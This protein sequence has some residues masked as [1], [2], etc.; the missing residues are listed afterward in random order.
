[1]KF[2]KIFAVATGIVLV[3][4]SVVLAAD[5]LSLQEFVRMAANKRHRMDIRK[6]SEVHMQPGSSHL[7]VKV[8]GD[9]VK[10]VEYGSNTIEVRRIKLQPGEVVET[11]ARGGRWEFRSPEKLAE[12]LGETAATPESSPAETPKVEAAAPAPEKAVAPAAKSSSSGLLEGKKG[13]LIVRNFEELQKVSSRR[14][15]EM[16]KDG[17]RLAQLSRAIEVTDD[18]LVFMGSNT[19]Q[20][21]GKVL[22]VG[23]LIYV[24]FLGDPD[25]D[26]QT[27]DDA[28]TTTTSVPQGGEVVLLNAPAQPVAQQPAT[29]APS[30]SKKLLTPEQNMLEGIDMAGV[31]ARFLDLFKKSVEKK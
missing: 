3:S 17:G 29:V 30:S 11:R 22:P 18:M 5:A 10:F 7:T 23:S 31:D 26:D 21:T 27:S 4:S 2:G 19:P 15:K 28:V 1:M 8:D 12:L 20:K 25:A 13:A 6:G 14:L 16:N 24:W 9:Y